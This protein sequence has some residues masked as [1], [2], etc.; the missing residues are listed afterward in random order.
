MAK[1]KRR[2]TTKSRREHDNKIDLTQILLQNR[3]IFLYGAIDDEQSLNIVRDLIALDKINNNPIALYI[4]SPG[5]F[6]SAGWAII[7]TIKGLR[8]PV[9]TMVMGKACSMAG[10]V[11]IAGKVRLMTE[12]S[13]WMAHDMAGGI[14]GDYTTKVLDRA[15]WLKTEQSKIFTFL[16][17]NTKLS[18]GEIAKAIAGELWL[19]AQ[20]CYTKG[21]ADKLVKC[22]EK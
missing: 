18:E 6:N 11:S 16:R 22:N 9:I 2:R 17:A 15:E 7:D 21:I 14:T 20:E 8:T 19:S 4:N 10:L 3:Q 12:H 13:V 5:G 1:L